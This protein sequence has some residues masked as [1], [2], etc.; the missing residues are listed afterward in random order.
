MLSDK[1]TG[2]GGHPG[3]MF[4]NWL[5]WYKSYLPSIGRRGEQGVEKDHMHINTSKLAVAVNANVW[6]SFQQQFSR[7]KSKYR[8]SSNSIRGYY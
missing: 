2:V 8:I 6:T 3:A 7:I 5:S 4:S 1:S